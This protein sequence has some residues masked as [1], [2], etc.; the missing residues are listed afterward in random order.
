MAVEK[1]GLGGLGNP[2]PG[3]ALEEQVPWERTLASQGLQEVVWGIA[4]AGYPGLEVPAETQLVFLPPSWFWPLLVA[5]GMY[6]S[7]LPAPSPKPWLLLLEL[8][9]SECR[10]LINTQRYRKLCPR[11]SMEEMVALFAKVLTE[12]ILSSENCLTLY[13]NMQL[14][15]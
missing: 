6:L 7:W 12:T 5:T 15:F 11:K 14:F 4:D 2:F 13:V 1:S 3:G 10:Q 8:A 9:M